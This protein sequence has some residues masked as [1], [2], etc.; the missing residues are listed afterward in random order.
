MKQEPNSAMQDV[1]SWMK[2]SGMTVKSAA[3]ADNPTSHPIG[4]APDGTKPAT[5]GARGAENTSDVKKDVRVSVEGAADSVNSAGG[6]TNPLTPSA[7]A[8]GEDKANETGMVKTKTDD[9]GTSHPAKAGDNTTD[10]VGSLSKEAGEI[11]ALLKASIPVAQ[12]ATTETEKAAAVAAG[13][14]TAE[15]A[16]AASEQ[17]SLIAQA[18]QI[19]KAAN[20]DAEAFLSFMSSYAQAKLEKRSEGEIPA[21]ALMGGPDAGG[22]AGAAPSPM[23]PP[24]GAGGDLGAGGPPPGAGAPPPG[25]A[26]GGP[27]GEGDGTQEL[28]K[29]IVESGVDIPSLIEALKP[30]AGGGEAAAGGAEGGPA[31]EAKET[32][33]KEE[34]EEEAAGEKKEASATD[35]DGA[36]PKGS[37][38]AVAKGKALKVAEPKPEV[39]KAAAMLIDMLVK[40][41]AAQRKV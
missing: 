2:R 27:G 7:K 22:A 10:K 14:Q 1:E 17:A 6:S 34:K 41:A 24:P 33:A 19:V 13:V 29:A 38:A 25:A 18:T 23:A 28:V 8:T 37:P 3:N 40:A 20:A 31:H 30:Y 16:L 12:A 4:S 11:V 32:P 9:P 26:A 15:A 35:V 39:Q 36:K 5:E 21:A